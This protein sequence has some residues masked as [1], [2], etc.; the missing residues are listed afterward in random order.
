MLFRSR[1]A[2]YQDA[3]NQ[4][5]SKKLVMA[6]DIDSL[7]SELGMTI[8]A[9]QA[10]RS[11]QLE[12]TGGEALLRINGTSTVTDPAFIGENVMLFDTSKTLEQNESAAISGLNRFRQAAQQAGKEVK[13]TDAEFLSAYRRNIADSTN[14]AMTAG[15][16]DKGIGSRILEQVDA[17][18]RIEKSNQAEIGR[19]H[20]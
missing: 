2:S 5:L 4:S 13:G 19:A 17:T 14:K 1:I 8:Q 16:L 20:V 15:T 7:V 18:G 6:N 10:V 12:R 9:Q 3:P 11:R